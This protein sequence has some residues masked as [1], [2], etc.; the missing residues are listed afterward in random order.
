MEAV[1]I[2]LA[3]QGVIIANMDLLKRHIML[4]LGLS[5]DD[6]RRSVSLEK[7]LL[8][9]SLQAWPIYADT[10]D[11]EAAPE[12]IGALSTLRDADDV[13]GETR[14]LIYSFHADRSVEKAAWVAAF[15]PVWD[16][17]RGRGLHA[18]VFYT[19]V[20][21]VEEIAEAMGFRVDQKRMRLEV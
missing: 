6:P 1:A 11:G 2:T 19:K 13:T 21:R 16:Y 10:T 3:S 12:I 18:I 9:G 5:L 17:A 14:L 4:G 20:D 7:A 15:Q 8:D